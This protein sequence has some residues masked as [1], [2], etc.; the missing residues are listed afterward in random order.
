M[1]QFIK[2]AGLLIDSLVIDLNVFK[3]FALFE[4]WRLTRRANALFVAI[5]HRGFQYFASGACVLSISRN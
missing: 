3:Y 5:A 4:T 2:F 1:W